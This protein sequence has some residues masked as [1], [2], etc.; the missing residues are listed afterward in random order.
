MQ[1]LLFTNAINAQVLNIEKYRKKNDTTEWSAEFG[2]NLSLLK[3]TKK[4]N[5]A[6]NYFNLDY[7]QGRSAFFLIS[8]INWIELKMNV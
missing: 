7:K 3:T 5:S 2:L 4:I 1:I 8:K 6:T